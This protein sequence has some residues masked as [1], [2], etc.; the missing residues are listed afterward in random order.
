[1]RLDRESTSSSGHTEQATRQVFRRE[2]EY[3]TI[4]YAGT[5][6]RLRDSMGL[7]HLACLLR[8]AGERVAST[9]LT[10]APAGTVRGAPEGAELPDAREIERARVTVTRAIRAAL[11]RLG[12]HHPALFEH[13]KATIRTGTACAYEPDPRLTRSWEL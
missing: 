8:R 5:V 12:E 6:C 2:G 4:E 10:A 9:E 11:E 13:F 7:R 1:M 3:W